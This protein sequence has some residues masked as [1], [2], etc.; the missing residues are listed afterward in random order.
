MV[1]K[2]D[3]DAVSLTGIRFTENITLYGTE[4]QILHN[5]LSILNDCKQP[6]TFKV[7]NISRG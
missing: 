5:L 6:G 1:V 2:I 7:T 4:K 3:R